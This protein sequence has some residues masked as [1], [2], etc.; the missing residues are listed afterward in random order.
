VPRHSLLRAR[1]S[2]SA[3]TN[4]NPNQR[5]AALLFSST[6]ILTPSGDHLVQDRKSDEVWTLAGRKTIKWIGYN[7]F[8]K[9]GRA[10]HDNGRSVWLL[11]S[12]IVPL[13]VISI[14]HRYIAFFSAAY[15]SDVSDQ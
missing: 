2:T 13:T 11:R 5:R 9:E 3:Q 12:M 15:S 1:R 7:K 6:K 8:K 14:S 4:N 10:W